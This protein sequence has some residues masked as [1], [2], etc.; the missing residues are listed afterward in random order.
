M[1]NP[2]ETGPKNSAE[3]AEVTDKQFR[4][5]LN[6]FDIMFLVIGSMI[7]SGWLFGSLYASAIS[8][9]AAIISWILGG[10]F[11]LFSALA[12]A[13]LGGMLPKS[14]AMVRYP[15]YSHG[16]LASLI[17]GWSYII[18]ELTPIEEVAIASYMASYIP[19][20]ISSTG[21][22][23]LKGV[24]VAFAIIVFF[25]L[26]N[27]FGVHI[28]GKTNTAVGWW[29]IIVPILT[30]ALLMGLFFH[31]ANFTA[32]PGGFAPYGW[33]PVFVAL[34]STGV[35]LAYL[36]FR[37]GVEYGSETKN[38][39]RDLPLGTIMG[40]LIVMI[41]YVLLQTAFIGAI[42]WSKLGL[43]PGDWANLKS[44]ILIHGPFYQIMKISEIP[45]LTAFGVIL[46]IDAIISP[47]GTGWI[48][49]GTAMRNLYGMA[50]NGHLPDWFLELNR[51]KVPKWAGIT[52]FLVITVFL[53]ARPLWVFLATYVTSA[54]VIS[55]LYI[56]PLL[57]VLRK[58][59]PNAP[60][61]FKLPAFYLFGALSFIFAYLIPYW[62]GFT[63][64]W[65][66][67]ALILAGL[68]LF[69][70]YTAVNRFGVKR[71]NATILGIIYWIVLVI[72]T[73]FLVYYD[74]IAPYN[75]IGPLP[76]SMKYVLPFVAYVVIMLAI[77]VAFIYI[78][79]M[80]SNEE[81]KQH[82]RAGWWVI[83]AIF[84]LLVLDFIGPFGVFKTPPL[85]FPWDTVT[86]IIIALI[87]FVWSVWSGIPTR[88]L[89]VVLRGMGV[90]KEEKK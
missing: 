87:L 45:I 64:M 32:L 7:G 31:P 18:S 22:L 55:Y 67:I 47:A 50:A 19:G 8:G 74:I 66:M 40:F 79:N 15:Q 28:M 41:I 4:K 17:F 9:P 70:M 43:K 54:V 52:V 53:I 3:K 60:R 6:V 71:S 25:F 62:A 42:D 72:S 85:T 80:W 75:S 20:L 59:A 48:G 37:Q 89:E 56:G 81:G 23:T 44:T 13:E 65:T 10:I 61:P 84:T 11:L 90:T 14:G 39:H 33:A 26:L 34:P 36:G 76:L 35:A 63:I 49:M 68:P 82:I 77:T 12:I 73:I 58:T 88:D 5:A 1:S 86:A 24:L 69:F 2:P 29:K 38:P 57:V 51:W 46:L 78:I 30:I 27:W 21:V 16:S 83:G